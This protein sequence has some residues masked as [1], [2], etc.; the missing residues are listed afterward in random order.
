MAIAA[1]TIWEVRNS[2][3]AGNVN[4]GGFNTGNANM[5]T[6]LT[7]DS[8]T[9]NTNSPVASSASYNF[10]AG[11]VGAWL[12]VKTGTNWT[13]G[14]YQIASV[15]S[16]KA[17][18]SAAIG[19]A[20][21]FDTNTGRYKANTVAGCATVGTPTGGTFSVDYSQQDAPALTATDLASLIG[22]TNPSTVTSA[23]APFGLN[24]VGNII[25]VTAGTNWTVG[26]YEI[27]SVSVVTAT[28]DRAV[29]TSATLSSGTARTGG[30]VL[31]GSTLDD[32]C[33]ESFTPGN[34]CF[35][36]T[37]THTQGESISVG[38]ANGTALL[39]INLIGYNT[40]RGDNPT[41]STRPLMVTGNST[42]GLGTF[43]TVQYIQISTTSAGGISA[44]AGT[45]MLYV[46]SINSSTTAARIAFT[47]TGGG[48]TVFGGEAV[49]Q[50]GI[51]MSVTADTRVEGCYIHDSDT[52]VNYNAPR[53]F[54][55]RNIIE[56]CKTAGILIGS[57]TNG[58]YVSGNTIYGVEAKR[59]I[60]ISMVNNTQSSNFVNNIIYGWATGINQA[61][62]QALSNY[63]WF[64]DFYNNT[65]D[66]T[67]YTKSET[68]LALDPVFVGASQ[69]TGATATTS[70]SV[71]TQS[72]GDFSS[73]TDNVDFLHLISGTGTTNDRFYLI[74]SHT[75]D[76]V[77]LNN[78][79]GTNATADKVWSIGVG[80]NFA[81]G[82]NLKATGFPGLFPGSESTGYLD[83]GAVQRQ[84]TG[85]G[86]G[87]GG[88]FIQ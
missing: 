86:G 25:H 10:V 14:F 5:M 39:P 20:S 24:H 87:S 77:T 31:I 23:T 27:V 33:F 52:G 83:T 48:Q 8:N 44:G 68:D 49:S 7:T 53:A 61:T 63:G 28:L 43:W 41:G 4:G 75:S 35:I 72:G 32:E 36:K 64:N 3:T 11:D 2:A 65:A 6:D 69:I 55:N 12:Y 51:G 81:I 73:V 50:N 30:S 38:T 26:W 46:K 82:T 18:L 57:T 45:S 15:A 54:I 22:T 60:G 42:F 1:T 62:A 29:G 47:V 66:V 34:I 78:A 13:P 58:N 59:G 74:T 37:G 56:N 85:S 70:G 21:Q 71:L 88:F 40:M 80:H 16:N 79:P 19:Q 17:T 67:L 76:T 9:A 84:E